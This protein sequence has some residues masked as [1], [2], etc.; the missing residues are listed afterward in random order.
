MCHTK[1][2]YSAGPYI[3]IGVVHDEL[4]GDVRTL[5]I[6][7]LHARQTFPAPTRWV[8]VRGPRSGVG[9]AGSRH[10]ANRFTYKSDQAQKD[11]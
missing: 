9:Q 3:Y 1:N 11:S 6:H 4:V 10:N 5:G 8:S 2:H 7:P